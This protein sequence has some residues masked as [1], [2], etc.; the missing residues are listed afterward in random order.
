MSVYATHFLSVYAVKWKYRGHI[1]SLRR[2]D[3]KRG[4]S[5]LEMSTCVSEGFPLAKFSTLAQMV[6]QATAPYGYRLTRIIVALGYFSIYVSCVS[7]KD[8]Y[9]FMWDADPAISEPPDT[10]DPPQRAGSKIC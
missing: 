1:I 3:L 5:L 2:T 4:C 7:I 10:S 9:V 8:C 6:E